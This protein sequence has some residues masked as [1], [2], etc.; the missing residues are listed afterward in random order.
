VNEIKFEITFSP[1]NKERMGTW[2]FIHLSLFTKSVQ[3][4]VLGLP[5]LIVTDDSM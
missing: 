3:L 5:S 1:Q 2:G 4:V